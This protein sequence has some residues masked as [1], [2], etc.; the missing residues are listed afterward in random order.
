MPTSLESGQ[1]TNQEVLNGYINEADRNVNA[2]ARNQTSATGLAILPV[3][4][5][6]PGCDRTVETYAFL[7][8][9]SNASFWSEE[10]A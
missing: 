4:V 6:A 7:D 1:M 8:S 2:N 3:K 10:L 5:K 9:G